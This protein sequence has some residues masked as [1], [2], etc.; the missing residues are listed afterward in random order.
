MASNPAKHTSQG[1]RQAMTLTEDYKKTVN[2]RANAD[3]AFAQALLEEAAVLYLHGETKTAKATL[4]MRINA[5][6]RL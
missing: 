4:H 2:A 6:H 3:P 5:T 1:K